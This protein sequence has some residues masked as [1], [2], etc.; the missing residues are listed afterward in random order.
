MNKLDV[1]HVTE[2]DPITYM[3]TL[4]FNAIYQRNFFQTLTKKNSLKI[5]KTLLFWFFILFVSSI[6][7]YLF[8]LFV[9]SE[10]DIPFRRRWTI[11]VRS[12]WKESGNQNNIYVW[13]SLWPQKITNKTQ[14][15]I[16]Y[17]AP[18]F[19]SSKEKQNIKSA[20]V[21]L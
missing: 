17:L 14:A 16:I 11:C 21:L 13:P 20:D 8:E 10:F 3:V 9:S 2:Y 12:M 19:T 15:R 1:I 6:C 5:F 4:D 7:I 18:S